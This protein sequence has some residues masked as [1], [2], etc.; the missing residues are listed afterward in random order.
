MYGKYPFVR[1]SRSCVCG[2]VAGPWGRSRV[3]ARVTGG[4]DP[5]P[6]PDRDP[7]VTVICVAR[8][9]RGRGQGAGGD[10]NAMHI[11]N[12]LDSWLR[13]PRAVTRQS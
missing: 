12:S 4:P 9:G 13:G 8:A 3:R 6:E 11:H 2:Y 7:Y 5:N 1:R 10:Y